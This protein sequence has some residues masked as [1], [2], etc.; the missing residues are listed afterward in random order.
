MSTAR[1]DTGLVGRVEYAPVGIAC[2]VRYVCGQVKNVGEVV[3]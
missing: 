3:Q 2:Q 1:R